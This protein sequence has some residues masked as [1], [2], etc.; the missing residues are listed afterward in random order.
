[1]AKVRVQ[2]LNSMSETG[3]DDPITLYKPTDATRLIQLEDKRQINP[4]TGTPFKN[5]GG[6][7]IKINEEDAKAIIAHAKAQGVSPHTALAIALQETNMG[8][9]DP[10]Y[11]SAWG[12]FE[13]Q[14][15]PTERDKNANILA[16]ALKEK[17]AYA[18][19]LRKKGVLPH[20]EEYDIQTYNGLGILTPRQTAGPHVNESYYGIPVTHANPLNLKKNPAYGKIVK[21]LRDEVISKNPRITELINT[22]PAY[23]QTSPSSA[24][25]VMVKVK[26]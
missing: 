11:G 25:K 21:Q 23:G 6:K 14:G 5:I 7:G 13:D 18:Q 19:E 3:P 9:L 8:Q 15:L 10:N 24:P 2:N 12:T 16:K 17:L 20:G 22:V 26:K 4:A 1:M